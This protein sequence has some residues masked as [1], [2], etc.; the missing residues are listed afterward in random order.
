MFKHQLLEQQELPSVTLPHGRFYTT[1]DGARYPSVTTVIGRQADKT[2]LWEWQKRVGKEKAQEITNRAATRGTRIHKI[3]EMYLMNEEGHLNGVMPANVALFKEMQ[4]I[5]DER[6]GTIF[7]VE[8]SLF[9]HRLR[10]AG[11]T[12]VIAEFDGIPSII[13]FKTA[14]RLKEDEDIRGYFQQATCYA[15]MTGERHTLKIPQLAIL[16]CTP[17]GPQVFVKKTIDYV[18]E[19]VKMFKNQV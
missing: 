10:T 9:S 6:I 16:I 3:F 8:H 19:V 18:P 12:D 15:L 7:G 2:W 14:S 4:P 5:V 13:D 1:P 17:E 11:K